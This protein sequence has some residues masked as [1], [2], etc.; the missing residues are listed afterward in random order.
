MPTTDK[1]PDFGIRKIARIK[2]KASSTFLDVIEFRLSATKRGRL[3][4][5]PSTV[6]GPGQFKNALLDAGAILP[7]SDQERKSL[8]SNVAKSDAPEQWVCEDHV[9]W[10]RNGKAY[11]TSNG[12][13]GN[14]PAKIVGINRS[15]TTKEPSGR[16]SKTGKWT[17]WRNSVGEGARHSSIMMLAICIALAAPL[18]YFVKRRSFTI[19]IFGKTR[20]GKTIATLLGASLP[21]I[22]RVEDLITWRITD[23][24]LEQRLPE[25]ND[26]MFPIDDLETMREKEGKE[27]YLRIRNIAYNLEQGW[28]MARHDS[29]TMAHG[30]MHE[31]WRCIAVT[32]YEK[33]IR[34]L[35]QSVNLDRQPG[36]TLRLID[37]PA[38]FDGLKHIFDRLP[39][40]LETG[41]FEEWKRE[42]F[43]KIADACEQNHGIPFRKYIGDLI[44]HGQSLR[45][46]VTECVGHFAKHVRGEGDGDVA[47]DVAEKFGLFFAG[48]ILGIRYGLLPWKKSEVLDAISKCY[49]GARDLLPDDGVALRRA[50]QALKVLLGDLAPTERLD[51]TDYA[52][53]NGYSEVGPTSRRYVI[54]REVFNKAFASKHDR[55]L[56][57][58]WLI[59]KHRIVLAVPKAAPPGSKPRPK[60]QHDWPDGERVRSYEIRI[61]RRRRPTIPLQNRELAD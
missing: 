51:T 61:P 54:K 33:S 15:K 35:A 45:N 50:I 12:V 13:I 4:L 43:S 40:T 44:A 11:V 17:A 37:V 3:M 59:R 31:H 6:N 55:E 5:A 41:D 60:I 39:A 14:V 38:L 58:D 26:A 2:D 27:K 49:F 24:Q 36:E 42:T 53:V 47:R 1:S 23:A 18:L 57:L 21:G 8:L 48:G 20:T 56:I 7:K 52:N 29:Y 22:G 30:G 19:N 32:S 25:Y 46:D 9:G 16:L 28:S 34:D 10:I